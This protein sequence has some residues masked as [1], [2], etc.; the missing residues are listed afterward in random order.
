MR[1]P[2]P[3]GDRFLRL[4]LLTAACGF[5]FPSLM[6]A[7]SLLQPFAPR[8]P[9]ESSSN[10]VSV[11]VPPYLQ[12][13]TTDTSGHDTGSQTMIPAAQ[14]GWVGDAWT[15]NAPRTNRF[16]GVRLQ[17]DAER[18]FATVDRW[19][20]GFAITALILLACAAVASCVVLVSL[21]YRR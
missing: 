3:R 2:A 11:E 17:T 8:L 4:F 18:D 14:S 16:D 9:G 12:P 20:R 19:R 10:D 5:G 1:H 15:R 13:R 21:A 6:A 7:D